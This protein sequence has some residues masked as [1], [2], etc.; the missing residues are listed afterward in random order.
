MS[1]AVSLLCSFSSHD[2]GSLT[3]QVRLSFK[4]FFFKASRVH[5][6]VVSL[7]FKW[8]QHEQ[9]FSRFLKVLFLFS[10]VSLCAIDLFI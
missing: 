3:P 1:F 9:A 5:D 6:G 8:P 2:T 10:R 4:Y 7:C